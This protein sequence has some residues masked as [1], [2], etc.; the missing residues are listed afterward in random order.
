MD[1]TIKGTVAI[2]IVLLLLMVFQICMIGIMDTNSLKGLQERTT[3]LSEALIADGLTSSQAHTIA[4]SMQTENTL[5]RFTNSSN[6]R[7]Q[8]YVTVMSGIFVTM[9]MCYVFKK[10]KKDQQP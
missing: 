5:L 6:A 7:S 4:Y 1:K 3:S 2:G 10:D 9:I 8:S